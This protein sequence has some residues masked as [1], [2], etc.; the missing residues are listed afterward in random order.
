MENLSFQ[1]FQTYKQ[2]LIIKQGLLEIEILTH[3]R[4]ALY[5]KILQ[6]YAFCI[7]LSFFRYNLTCSSQRSINILTEIL[8]TNF[9]DELIFL[10]HTT[11]LL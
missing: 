8:Y 2:I 9:F 3:F 6:A 5:I 11:R 7:A 1:I 10:H 4:Q